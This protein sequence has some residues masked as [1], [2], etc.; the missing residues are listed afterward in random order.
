MK[1]K[2]GGEGGDTQKKVNILFEDEKN[3]TF[4]KMRVRIAATKS[5]EPREGSW[6]EHPAV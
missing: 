6:A 3:W 4:L 5:R 2:M 1:G